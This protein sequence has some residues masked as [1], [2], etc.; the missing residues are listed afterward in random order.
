[1]KTIKKVKVSNM[2]GNSGREVVNQ[3][4]IVT[5]NG[6]YFQ[7]YNT[8]IAFHSSK[9]GKTYLDK[10]SWDCSNTT[11]KYRNMFLGEDKK[12]TESKIKDGIYQLVN[13]N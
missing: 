5:P 9:N 6:S 1:M 7:S 12:Q 4:E 11:G 10:S 3:F 13:L 2:V 8:L